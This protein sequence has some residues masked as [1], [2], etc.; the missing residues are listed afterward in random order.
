MFGKLFGKPSRKNLVDAIIEAIRRADPDVTLTYD[1]AQFRIDY[2]QRNRTGR[3]ILANFFD[4]Y[5]AEDSAGRREMIERIAQSISDPPA[6]TTAEEA[7]ELLMPRVR[8]RYHYPLL[9]LTF[10]AE[11]LANSSWF[12]VPHRLLADRLAISL[13]LDTEASIADV[14]PDNLDQWGLSFDQ[15][16]DLAMVNLRRRTEPSFDEALPGIFMGTWADYYDTSRLLLPEL[17]ADLNI[18]GQPVAAVPNRAVLLVTGD[19]DAEN[20]ANLATVATSGLDDTHPVDA[21]SIRYDGKSWTPFLP[22]E[23]NLAGKTR[24]AVRE[25]DAV[26]YNRQ[27]DLL[28]EIFLRDGVDLFAAACQVVRKEDLPEA[29]TYC[30]WSNGVKSLLPQTEIIGLMSDPIAGEQ[31]VM[32]DRAVV[33]EL[34]GDCL[35]STEYDPP[36]IK[37]EKF[38]DA[39]TFDALRERARWV[40]G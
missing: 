26:H 15:A 30:M 7:R 39:A 13:A 6:P 4:G 36:R 28:Q 32:A 23:A 24:D 1:E 33:E 22:D 40:I 9:P 34:A 25:S 29:F 38:P 19:Q 20:L 35:E 3:L 8:S 18:K 21:A 37:V 17:L 10:E 16:L 11:G 2:C 12:E 5:R 31:V 14:T 27:G